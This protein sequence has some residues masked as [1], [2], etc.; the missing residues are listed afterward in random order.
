MDR[1]YGLDE[2][3]LSH[4]C[5][6]CNLCF[7]KLRIGGHDTEGCIHQTKLFFR[8]AFLK[9]RYRIGKLKTVW[10]FSH[11]GYDLS[12]HVIDNITKGIDNYKGAY[13][14]TIG[15]CQAAGAEAALHRL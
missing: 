13:L 14:K 15:H 11:P 8:D 3:G 4:L 1:A 6:L 10:G 9:Q 2:S 12:C 7:I 5:H